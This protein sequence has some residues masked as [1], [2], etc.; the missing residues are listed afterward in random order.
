MQRIL[1]KWKYYKI[2]KA[3]LNVLVIG[4][5]SCGKSTLIN[6]LLNERGARECFGYSITKLYSQYVH[7]KYPITFT[8]TPGF[9]DD[10]CLKWME[11]FL[12]VYNTFSKKEEINFI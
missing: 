12:W 2:Y 3:T 8:D 5:P 7:K 9:D 6:L 4:R 1:W 10:E 11:R